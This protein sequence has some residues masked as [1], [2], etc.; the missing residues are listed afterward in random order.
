MKKHNP[1]NHENWLKSRDT[2]KS[3]SNLTSRNHLGQKNHM[4]NRA[5]LTN[6][7]NRWKQLKQPITPTNSATGNTHSHHSF[8]APDGTVIHYQIIGNGAPLVLLHGGGQRHLI[9]HQQ[10]EYFKD[11]YKLILIDAKQLGLSSIGPFNLATRSLAEDTIHVLD[12]LHIRKAIILGYGDG[13]NTALQLALKAPWMAKALIIV[14]ANIVSPKFNVLA[15]ALRNFHTKVLSFLECL[16]F[17]C[18]SRHTTAQSMADYP[19]MS[20]KELAKIEFPTLVVSAGKDNRRAAYMKK[21][22]NCIQT[23]ESVQISQADHL[24]I[25]T[26]AS[27]YNFIIYNFLS[28]LDK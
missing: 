12:H 19:Q 4:T 16:N 11:N 23:S 15:D 14:D 18:N 7:K 1:K 5:E 25:M 17:P 10:V 22:A 9:F 27:E 24:G 2:L 3:R 6:Q 28:K 13:G 8:L 20:A 26:H 21:L